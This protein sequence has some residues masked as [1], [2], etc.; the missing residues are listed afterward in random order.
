MTLETQLIDIPFSGGVDEKTRP[1]L[2]APPNFLTLQN[3]RQIRTGSYQKRPG[4]TA[5]SRALIS[6]PLIPIGK[7]LLA[8]KDETIQTDGAHLYTRSQ[9]AGA[10]AAVAGLAPQLQITD[11]PVVSLQGAVSGYDSVYL[12]GYHVAAHSIPRA[13]LGAPTN[14]S[15]IVTIIDGATG[16]VVIAPT[17]LTPTVL[18]GVA[19]WIRLVTVGTVVVLLYSPDGAVGNV[20]RF[21]WIDTASASTL[22]TGWATPANLVTDT[23]VTSGIPHVFDACSLGGTFVLAYVNNTVGLATTTVTVRSYNSAMVQQAVSS[24]ACSAAAA[25]LGPGCLSISGG[26]ADALFLGYPLNNGTVFTVIGLNPSTLATSATAGTIA[27][28][29]GTVTR[30]C[31]VIWTSAGNG[32]VVFNDSDAGG[33]SAN[34]RLYTRQFSV[35]AGQITANG[36]PIINQGINIDSRPF[37]VAGRIFCTAR[38]TAGINSDPGQLWLVD[39][40]QTVSDYGV[41]FGKPNLRIAGNITPRLA[42]GGFQLGAVGSGGVGSIMATTVSSISA[43]KFVLASATRKNATGSS[44]DLVTLDFGATNVAQSAVLGESLALA[45]APPSH[46][47]GVRVS[48]IGFFQKPVINTTVAVG[49]GTN[50]TGVYKYIAVYEQIDARGQWHQS[51]PSDPLTGVGGTN[52]S[53]ILSVSSLQATNRVDFLTSDSPSPVRIALYRTGDKGNVYY[54]VHAMGTTN[55][56]STNFVTL[57]E[58][59]HLTSQLGAPLYT[60]PGLPNQAQVKVT[61]PCFSSMVAHGDRLFGADGK[62]LWYS[63]QSVYG[64]GYWFAD[65]FQFTIETGGA[66]TALAS[67]DGALVVFKRNAICFIDG[68]GPADNGSGGE[69]SP[70]QFIATDVGCTEPRSVV[71]TPDGIIFQSLRGFELLTR[72]RQLSPFFGNHV[73]V[74]QNANPVTT[75]AVLDEAKGVVNFTCLPTEASAT[76]ITLAYNMVFRSWTSSTI[77]DGSITNAGA[78]SAVMVGQNAGTTPVRVWLQTS[79]GSIFQESASAYL[80]NGA[81]VT[82]TMETAWIHE[83]GVAG[84][85]NVISAVL[86]AQSLTDH[87]LTIQVA[88]DYSASYTDTHT[89]TAAQIAALTTAR[90]TLQFDLTLPECNAF[91]VKVTDATPSSG[92]VGTGQGP[93][94]FGLQILG[95]T[96]G[97]FV[98]LPEANRQ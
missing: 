15:V 49:V 8:Y 77:G 24:V 55:D 82:T 84:F 93:A 92:V 76:G 50:V 44:L 64:E 98:P 85:Q 3:H 46:Y 70:P 30:M 47:D 14:H 68:Q 95:G 9:T 78:R 94:L 26:A 51:S 25:Y 59:N 1:E 81:W 35:L 96:S 87:D 54:R 56:P 11:Q 69:F 12:G 40:T 79:S 2:V 53:W 5:L 58:D 31:G 23:S 73:E 7:R 63:G 19:P 48:E 67:M 37:S 17:N 88:Y 41:G 32:T 97:A 60:Q 43:T 34:T 36:A 39:L 72:A 71:L 20:I 45:G 66:I 91:R 65:I 33:A 18:T 29:T 22:N 27:V 28:V 10:W 6:G 42:Y 61:P 83:N 89:W 90:A 4:H 52:T 13:G 38:P 80:D 21:S 74:S 57:P 75:S 86:Q 16:A 62:T